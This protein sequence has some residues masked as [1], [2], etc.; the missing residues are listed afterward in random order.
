M[1]YGLHK[2][3][4]NKLSQ[5]IGFYGR[6][7]YDTQPCE[8]KQQLC[9]MYIFDRCKKLIADLPKY[10]KKYLYALFVIIPQF[11]SGHRLIIY[12]LQAV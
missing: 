9:F 2:V 8:F 7:G 1:I 3:P 12:F 6:Q 4:I 5:P 10:I 11:E